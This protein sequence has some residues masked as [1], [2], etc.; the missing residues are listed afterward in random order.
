MPISFTDIRTNRQWKSSTGLS[1]EQFQK[2]V[3]MFASAYEELFG[4]SISNRQNNSS[5]TATFSSYEEFLF[6]GLYSIKSGLTYDLLAL[7]F[8]LSPS[9]A[10]ANQSTCLTVLQAALERGGWMPKREYS[11]EE[12]F[13]AH[14]QQEASII[15]DATEH[16]TQ[17]PQK[18]E[19]QKAGYS[20]KKKPTP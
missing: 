7:S 15:I 18:Q 16:R 5:G 1:A 10:H 8:G 6:F 3:P 17:R 12:E 13:K 9:N 20:G 11:T 2:L 4:E 19:D 14:W